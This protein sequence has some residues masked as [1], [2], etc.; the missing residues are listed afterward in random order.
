MH[1]PVEDRARTLFVQVRFL[2]SL[3]KYRVKAFINVGTV[4][5]LP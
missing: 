2:K 4:N 5:L 1:Y 3:V